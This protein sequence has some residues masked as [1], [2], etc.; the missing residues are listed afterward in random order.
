MSCQTMVSP[1]S[2]TSEFSELTPTKNPWKAGEI[3]A[4][5]SRK[6]LSEGTRISQVIFTATHRYVK[7]EEDQI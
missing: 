3:A 7:A 2:L 6:A 4:Q 1:C 5:M